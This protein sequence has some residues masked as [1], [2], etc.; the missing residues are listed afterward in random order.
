MA[1]ALRPAT[2]LPL[3]VAQ[4]DNSATNS[5][6]LAQVASS[7]GREAYQLTAKASGVVITGNGDY[8]ITFLYESGECRLMIDGVF[9]VRNG[10]DPVDQDIHQ[11]FT[12]GRSENN[13]YHIT[14]SNYQ[15][16]ASFQVTATIYGDLN[17]DS[18]GVVLIKKQ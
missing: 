16:G 3:T 9:V 7:D 6:H 18:N 2:G 13:S 1:L 4:I 5:I 12:G 17:A 14:V 11:G 15:T 8:V 10:I